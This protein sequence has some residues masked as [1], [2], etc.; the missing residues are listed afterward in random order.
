[1][2]E[3]IIALVKA[4]NDGA[5]VDEWEEITAV[6]SPQAKKQSGIFPKAGAVE[7]GR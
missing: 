5:E 7:L 4:Y 1:M 6:E 3:K 2:N